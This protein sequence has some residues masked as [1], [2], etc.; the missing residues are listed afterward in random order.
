M[1][2]N[3]VDFFE[4]M[5]KL[6]QQL[7]HLFDSCR[8]LLREEVQSQ[9]AV[10][11]NEQSEGELEAEE[12]ADGVD[13]LDEDDEKNSAS[14]NT[15]HLSTFIAELRTKKRNSVNANL[16]AESSNRLDTDHNRTSIAEVVKVF[17]IDKYAVRMPLNENNDLTVDLTVK[18]GMGKNFDMFRLILKKQGLEDFFRKSCFGVYLD[19]PEETGARFQMKMVYGLMKRRIL[20]DAKDEL[21]INYCGM[22]VCF[23]LKEFA[24][25]TGLRCHPCE[26][27]TVVLNKPARTSKTAKEAKKVGKGGKD[28]SETGL[29]ELVGKSYKGDKLLVDLQSKTMSKKHK[30]SLCLVWFVHC[31]LMAKDTSLNIPL[32]LLKLAED[33]EAFNNHG[34]GRESFKLTVDYLS[35]ELKPTVKTVNL[36]GFPWA[37]MAWAFEA[38]PHLRQ[39]VKDYPSEVS[40]PRMLRWLTAKSN[41]RLSVDLFNPPLE[42]VVHPWLVPTVR[43]LEM[44]FLASFEPL[45]S[46]P[47]KMIEGMKLELAGVTAIKRES[48]VVDVGGVIAGGQPTVDNVA[49]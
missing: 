34:W 26:L 22:P 1:A 2:C 16:I 25:V 9:E 44:P 33:Y 45:Q 47:D 39:Q 42:E 41:T 13:G 38:I 3:L 36:Y 4:Q 48:V 35:K 28:K 11:T 21:W 31:V 15:V 23:G 46:V 30:Q 49:A 8:H 18:S 14:E 6:L 27:P 5:S 10:D 32:G 24:I 19:L 43:E 29:V 17:S 12:T 40:F 20:S 7:Q 37:F